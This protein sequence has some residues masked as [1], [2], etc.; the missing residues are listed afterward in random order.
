MVSFNVFPMAKNV[1]NAEETKTFGN[2]ALTPMGT[3]TVGS[4]FLSKTFCS[5]NLR[6]IIITN[7]GLNTQIVQKVAIFLSWCQIKPV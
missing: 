5:T 6:S 4:A 2:V 7:D 3:K 1:Y